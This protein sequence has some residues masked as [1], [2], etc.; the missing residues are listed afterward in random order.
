MKDITH[1]NVIVT[2]LIIQLHTP[3]SSDTQYNII[4]IFFSLG[5]VYLLI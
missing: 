2:A 1:E 5:L 4:I 3:L